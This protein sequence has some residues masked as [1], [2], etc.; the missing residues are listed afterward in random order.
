MRDDAGGY[1]TI[2]ANRRP[3][4]AHDAGFLAADLLPGRS[5]PLLVF[6]GYRSNHG[7]IGIQQIDGIQ[8][9]AHTDLQ[10]PQFDGIVPE[11]LQSGQSTEFEVCQRGVAARLIDIFKRPAQGS[12]GD[13]RAINPDAFVVSDQVWGSVG[14]N[15]ISGI[16][17]NCVEHGGAG[18]LAVGPGNT[19]HLVSG[20]Q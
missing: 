9:P 1:V 12:V 3:S 2:A 20:R 5:Q 19:D 6:E 14:T 8:P 10:N 18:T 4:R 16:P 15:G 11:Q 17:I 7:D 13:L